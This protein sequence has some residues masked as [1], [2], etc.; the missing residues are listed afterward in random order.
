MVPEVFT[1]S[2]E[3]ED[4]IDPQGLELPEIGRYRAGPGRL[5]GLRLIHVHLHGEPL[6]TDDLTDLS[7]LSLDAVAVIHAAAEA[8]EP[9]VSWAH[10]LPENPDGNRWEVHED[11][12]AH[13]IEVD[14][15]AFIREIEGEIGRKARM[16]EA[17]GAGERA[18][19]VHLARPG[20]PQQEA[21]D[22]SEL[23]ELAATAGL[24]VVD[25]VVQRRR[26]DNKTFI[27]RGRLTDLVIE[28]MQ[29][30]VDL[31]VMSPGLTPAQIRA[32]SDLAEIR[33]IDRTQ[34]I[35]D[36]FAQRARSAD[37]KVQVELAQLRHLL[38]R[39]AGSGK[40]MSRLEGGS[41][42]RGPGETKLEVDRR[43]IN[44]RIGHL[45]R[46]LKQLS[47]ERANRRRRRTRAGIPVISIVGYT[48]AGK[49]TLL[50]TLTRAEAVAENK[51][52]AT[53][54]PFSKRLRFPRDR[55]VI[56]TD[57]VGFI[58]ELPKTLVQAFQATLEELEQA[59]LFLH[60]VDG[61]SPHRDEQKESIERILHD[62]DLGTTPRIV[63]YNKIDL[64][65]DPQE[66]AALRRQDAYVGSAKDRASLRPLMEQIELLI[67]RGSF[68]ELLPAQP[69]DD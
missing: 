5:R 48:N 54:D 37:G 19:L 57:T 38:P 45:E 12:P 40:A 20:D 67:D 51:L 55:E 65:K 25:V 24:N 46:A 61:A 62:M 6:A 2:R 60:V 14:F 36:I 10:L 32:I 7:L 27:G 41:G 30:H 33:V 52:F 23:K 1:D 64:V 49:S 18:I 34:L 17:D 43:R 15:P 13:R 26:P 59:D 69:L 56:L 4:R 11:L 21:W 39:L 44:K 63:F 53:L 8:A 68:T 28:A 42:G 16:V 31:L 35:L 66:E 29:R 58:R 22:V 9:L 47:R 50:N 3:V